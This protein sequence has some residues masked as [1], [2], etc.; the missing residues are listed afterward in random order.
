[1]IVVD[2]EMSGLDSDKC[3]I[4][5]IGAIDLETNETFFDESRIDDEDIIDDEALKVIGKSE[6]E[7]RDSSKQSQKELINK[8]FHWAKPRAKTIIG[9]VP[10]LDVEFLTKRARKYN[11]YYPFHH[12]T[13]DLH[14]VAQTK[15][16]ENK[17]K[18]LF[19]EGHSDLGTSNI[20]KFT[21][22]EGISDKRKHNA[23]E[24]ANLVAEAFMRLIYGKNLLPEYSKFKIPEYLKK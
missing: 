20:T 7:L 4:W 1:M 9:E 11:L 12:R 8:F 6:A 5:Q 18:F 14:S 2:C 24:D 21:G 22:I 16:F 3:G 15:Y 17:G 10:Q 23:L 13:F 19:K